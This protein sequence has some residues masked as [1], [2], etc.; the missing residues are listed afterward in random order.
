LIEVKLS[1]FSRCFGCRVVVF[2]ARFNADIR[3]LCFRWRIWPCSGVLVL[4]CIG[5]ASFGRGFVFLTLRMLREFLFFALTTVSSSLEV[6]DSA[7]G[8]TNF[9]R[10]FRGVLVTFLRALKNYSV[11][12]LF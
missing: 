3:W 4:N 10:G 7:G 12:S 1:F 5:L 9:L 6:S 11:C 2:F 8:F